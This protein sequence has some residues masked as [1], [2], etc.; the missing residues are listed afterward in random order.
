[1]LRA[2]LL[3][4]LMIVPA[5][6]HSIYTDLHEFRD[7]QGQRCCGDTDCE[8]VDYRMQPNGDAIIFSR[9]HKAS[10]KIAAK[11]IGWMEVPGGEAFE[12]HWCGFKRESLDLNMMQADPHFHTYCMFIRPGGV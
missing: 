2:I 11:K 3:S 7:P 6:G 10:V 9:R 1:M 4:I 12:A 8:V 5:W